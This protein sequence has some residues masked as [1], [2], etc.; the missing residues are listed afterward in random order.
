M[1]GEAALAIFWS[2]LAAQDSVVAVFFSHPL[3]LAGSRRQFSPP[4]SVD[5]PARRRRFFPGCGLGDRV[6]RMMSLRLPAA[7]AV[8]QL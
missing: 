4:P 1:F 3:S 7:I 2:V 8:I 5:A 6:V